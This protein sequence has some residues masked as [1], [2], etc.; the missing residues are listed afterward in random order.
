M[1]RTTRQR[2]AIRAALELAGRPLSPQEILAAARADLPQLGLATVYRTV[3]GLLADGALRTVE[4]PGTPARYE[5]AGKHHH[6]H[7]HC[8]GCDGVFE[9]EACPTGIRG[10]LPGGF[11][12]EEHEIILYG[13]CAA[14]GARR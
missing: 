13:L 1:Q 3:K 7:F 14:C 11:R 6:H 2:E 4:L 8:R 5:L 10:L 12:L 9:V